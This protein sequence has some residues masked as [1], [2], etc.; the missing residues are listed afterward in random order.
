MMNPIG[1]TDLSA[2]GDRFVCRASTK[3]IGLR[4]ISKHELSALTGARCSP[5]RGALHSRSIEKV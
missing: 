3:W 5:G 1:V 4:E 2:G